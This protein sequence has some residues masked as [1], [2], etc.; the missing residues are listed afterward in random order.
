MEAPVL[1]TERLILRGFSPGDIEA[2]SR[3]LA[4]REAMWDLWTIPDIPRDPRDYADIYVGGSIASWRNSGYG[5]WAVWTRPPAL[6][7]E[8]ELIGFCGFVIDS[9]TNIRPPE[10]LEMGWGLRPDFQGRGLALEAA[11]AAVTYG[12]QGLGVARL[13]AITSPENAPSRKLME[14]LG[15]SFTETTAAYGESSVLYSLS[16][17]DLEKIPAFLNA[18][19][20]N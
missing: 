7:R 10:G 5:F 14:R 1:A 18:S 9:H 6:S 15:F 3:L 8:A 4:D 16:R 12:F 19:P 17:E 20:P 11:T 2:F 13:I